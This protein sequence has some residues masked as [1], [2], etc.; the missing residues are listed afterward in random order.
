MPEV[1]IQ[2]PY[3]RLPL[4]YDLLL[5]MVLPID[6]AACSHFSQV[7]I[8]LVPLLQSLLPIHIAMNLPLPFVGKGVFLGLSVGESVGDREGEIVGE[9]V[10]LVVVP[11]Q[12]LIV[13]L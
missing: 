7:S 5:F 10:V 4:L 8:A 12:I 13:E 1:H 9:C 2:Q 3:G 11:S 6:F